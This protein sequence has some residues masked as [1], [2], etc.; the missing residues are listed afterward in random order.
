[1]DPMLLDLLV[2]IAASIIYDFSKAFIV[3]GNQI[4]TK[5][6]HNELLTLVTERFSSES[7]ENDDLS[8]LIAFLQLPQITDIVCAFITYKVTGDIKETLKPKFKQISSS[9]NGLLQKDIVQYLTSCYIDSKKNSIKVV[10]AMQIEKL[11]NVI[12]QIV[13]EFYMNHSDASDLFSILMI[14]ERYDNGVKVLSDNLEQ[15]AKHIIDSLKYSFIQPQINFS[16]ITNRYSNIAKEKLGRAHIYLLDF[17][18]FNKFYVP[19]KLMIKQSGYEFE[20][21]L[22]KGII[23]NE[24]RESDEWM[25]IFDFDQI[26]YVVGGAGFGKSLF[27]RNIVL[28][29]DKMNL[30]GQQNRLVILGDLKNFLDSNGTT[31]PVI[32]FLQDSLVASSGM[33]YNDFSEEFIMHYLNSGSC[34]ILLDA[35][36]EVAE[37]KRNDVHS[38]IRSFFK[39]TNPNNKVCITSRSRG[40]I[41]MH[42]NSTVL[43]ISPLTR[44]QIEEYI[45]NIIELKKFD[46]A[47][48]ADFM[49]RT[50]P[51][52]EKGFLTSCLILSLLVNIYKA[53][54][55]LPDNK[56]DLYQKCFEYI[57]FKRETEG[58]K[59][60]G[61][62][63]D[64]VSPLMNEDTFTH[65]AQLCAPNNQET[66][67]VQ[68]RSVLIEIN[69][70]TFGTKAAA[71]NAVGEFLKF[72]AN[73]TELFV[74]GAN[75]NSYKFFHRSFLDY[76]FALYI[77]KYIDDEKIIYAELCKFSFDSEVYELILALLKNRKRATYDNLIDYVVE[78]AKIELSNKTPSFKALN[79]L[80]QFMHEIT[81]YF[82][83]DQLA[84]IVIANS[85]KLI[86]KDI[87]KA[88]KPMRVVDANSVISS[89]IID[90]AER[91]KAIIDDY[92]KRY[93]I[94]SI[95]EAAYRIVQFWD[96]SVNISSESAAIQIKR[97]LYFSIDRLSFYASAYISIYGGFGLFKELK[98][99]NTGKKYSGI[100]ATVKKKIKLIVDDYY[101]LTE[102]EQSKIDTF[103]RSAQRNFRSI[104]D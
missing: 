99:I 46:K 102:D 57:S 23:V 27:L 80:I 76:F 36:D 84:E 90:R 22:A 17:F 63:W 92:K 20:F 30:L 6:I 24:N 14:N 64:K 9:H 73:R 70:R 15:I 12:S 61:Y 35:L 53:E 78:R 93:E 83:R 48:K 26:I 87:K 19:P 54:L 39:N 65:L 44:S 68:V 67:G 4:G 10:S 82:Y 74:P 13:R 21:R 98:R 18:D 29:F 8:S 86:Q 37:A 11:L 94:S 103:V 89:I 45:D 50:I 7:I 2:N 95:E 81:E 62:D 56:L 5:D 69:I 16:A 47:N 77:F 66:D 40:F 85:E 88:L 96:H 1:M 34:V 41:P 43:H 31:K 55:A 3:R 97:S 51:L 91:R 38:T 42:E 25:H 28:N 75:E 72:C 104:F 60:T 58:N 101:N 100:S 32:Q 79:I 59:S 49:T 71:T 33:G 52:I